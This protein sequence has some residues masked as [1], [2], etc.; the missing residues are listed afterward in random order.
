MAA[1]QQELVDLEWDWGRVAD[2]LK[3]VRGASGEAE[4]KFFAEL[5]EFFDEEEGPKKKGVHFFAVRY[6]PGAVIMAKGTTSDYAAVHLSGLVR[7]RQVEPEKRASGAGC[8]DQPRL[9]RLEDLLLNTPADGEAGRPA[10]RL[11]RLL[12]RL[13]RTF[14]GL[15]LWLID[16]TRRHLPQR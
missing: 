4:E 9:R 12:A 8:W 2:A 15:P 16:F 7:V 14:P 6:R 10:G 11:D 5:K 1:E 3:E 13:Y